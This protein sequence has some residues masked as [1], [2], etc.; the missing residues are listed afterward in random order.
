MRCILVQLTSFNRHPRFKRVCP[1]NAAAPHCEALRGKASPKERRTVN[2]FHRLEIPPMRCLKQFPHQGRSG[3]IRSS[4]RKPLVGISRRCPS[5][6]VRT[7]LATV[8]FH[9]IRTLVNRRFGRTSYEACWRMRRPKYE[10][11]PW[12][13]PEPTTCRGSFVLM[14]SLG[15]YLLRAVVPAVLPLSCL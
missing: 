3:A 7:R 8:H 6:V 12:Q 1:V 13:S 5:A 9:L 15:A 11:Y 10:M 2:A 4:Q 14:G